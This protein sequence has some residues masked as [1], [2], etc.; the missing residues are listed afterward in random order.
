MTFSEHRVS[1]CDIQLWY[2][3]YNCR[4]SH[5]KV[6]RQIS[7]REFSCRHNS[8]A[9]VLLHSTKKFYRKKTEIL[10]TVGIRCKSLHLQNICLNL[11]ATLLYPRFQ[12]VDAFFQCFQIHYTCPRNIL[13]VSFPKSKR[14]QTFY[15]IYLN[16]IWNKLL[17]SLAG[18]A[19]HGQ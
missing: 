4:T 13:P 2:H 7:T 6:L 10:K 8:R 19:A 16:L 9:M 1:S 11:Q 5:T 12:T 3:P 14:I 15:F 17:K 18:F